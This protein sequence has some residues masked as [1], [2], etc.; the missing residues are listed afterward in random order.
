MDNSI[1]R[2]QSLDRIKSPEQLNDYLHVTSPAIWVVLVAVLL[3]LGAL[4]AWSAFTA[5]VK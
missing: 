1:F 3:L 5:Y 2:K 4:F